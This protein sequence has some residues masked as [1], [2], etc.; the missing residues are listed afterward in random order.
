MEGLV[1][2]KKNTSK[3]SQIFCQLRQESQYYY[4]LV[5]FPSICYHG[6]FPLSPLAGLADQ[7]HLLDVLY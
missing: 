2:M 1:V 4:Y 6:I 5:S 3:P 7:P